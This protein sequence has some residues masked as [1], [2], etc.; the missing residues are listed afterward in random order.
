M[1]KSKVLLYILHGSWGTESEDSQEVL[2]ASA[3]TQPLEE[4]LSKIADSRAKDYIGEAYGDTI[5]DQTDRSYTLTDSIGEY[6]NFFITEHQVELP[7]EVRYQISREV[8]KECRMND[9][10]CYLQELWEGNNLEDWKYEYMA[11]SQEIKQGIFRMYE[12]YEDC[13]ISH[14]AT[15]DTA[16]EEISKDIIL[17]DKALEFLWQRLGDIPV[18]DDGITEED[19]IGYPAGTDREEIWKWFDEHHSKGVAELVNNGR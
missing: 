9:I 13:N 11:N 3:E 8:D 16:Y 19:F 10:E 5:E 17:N 4:K 7:D 18:N 2:G 1:E 12:K 6:A 14:N 15:M